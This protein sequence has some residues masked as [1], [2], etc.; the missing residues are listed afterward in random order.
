[1]SSTIQDKPT[2][3][4]STRL[5]VILRVNKEP[6][7]SP[8]MSSTILNYTWVERIRQVESLTKTLEQYS[9]VNLGLNKFNHS[10]VT[11]EE[12]IANLSDVIPDDDYRPFYVSRYNKLGYNRF[13]ELA[14]KA[15]AGKNPVK[16]FCWMLRHQEIVR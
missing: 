4:Q 7:V 12:V 13:L 5:H 16:L 2:L 8:G 15:R 14:N 11:V 1:L 10:N 9:N 6:R 3:S